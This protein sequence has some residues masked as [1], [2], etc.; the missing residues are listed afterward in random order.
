LVLMG[1]GG[2]FAG[3]L[4]GLV[5]MSRPTLPPRLFVGDAEVGGMA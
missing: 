3:A 2:M 5:S 4:A 1:I